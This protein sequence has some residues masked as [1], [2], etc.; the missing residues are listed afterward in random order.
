MKE[1]GLTGKQSTDDHSPVKVKERNS[2]QA[3]SSQWGQWSWA[4]RT[5]DKSA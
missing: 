1:T 4:P 2:G 5:E 3:H